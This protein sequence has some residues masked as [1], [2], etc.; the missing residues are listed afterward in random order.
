MT[1]EKA[2]E[3]I[4]TVLTYTYIDCD[5]GYDNADGSVKL[6]PGADIATALDLAIAALRE[7]EERRW[8]P[9][10]ERLPETEANV[11][12]VANGNPHSNI[13]LERA[14]ELAIFSIDEGWIL[15]MW[16]EWE[17]PDVTHWMPLPEP[18]KEA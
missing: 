7:Q 18:P 1:I 13:T 17:D 5:Y 12:V 2:V 14:Y 15:E 3:T 9:V 4:S 10:T 11:L 6:V 8:I 16:P